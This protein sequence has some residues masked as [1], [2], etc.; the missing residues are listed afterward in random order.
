MAGALALHTLFFGD[1]VREPGSFVHLSGVEVDER[2]LELAMRLIETLKTDWNPQ[3]YSDTYREDLLRMIAEKRPLEEA[4]PPPG[5]PPARIEELM[6]ALKESVEAAKEGKSPRSA[7]PGSGGRPDVQARIDELYALPLDRFIPERDALAKELRSAGD[8][9]AAELVKSQRKPVVAAWALNVLAR[10]DPSGLE[11]LSAV[12]RRLRAQ[13]RAL[14][15][16][17]TEPLRTATEERRA[18]VARLAGAA[19]AILEREA[20]T[21]APRRRPHEHAGR[22]RRGRGGRGRARGRAADEG[23]QA[24]VRVR[25]REWARG[26]RGGRSA[27]RAT[28]DEGAGSDEDAAATRAD[29]DRRR[30]RRALERELTQARTKQRRAQEAVE[31]ARRQLE[32]LER[33]RADAKDR[34]R[35]AEA[36]QRGTAVGIKRLESRLAKLGG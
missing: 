17:D 27:D 36:E 32:D 28:A 7:R 5:R 25:R 16:G 19:R 20:P 2:Q 6:R 4:E 12:G 21:R 29:A 35:A 8:R 9:E 24:P 26:A 22:G 15:G 30:E 18:I 1:E 11:D 23:A 34:V 14:S 31:R 33:R 10:E 13:Q 3:A